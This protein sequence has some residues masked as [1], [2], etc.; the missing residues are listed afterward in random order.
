L[1]VVALV[2]WLTVSMMVF[3]NARGALA[4]AVTA[5]FGITLVSC[6]IGIL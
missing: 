4:A 3:V 6:E 5:D 1:A 2:I